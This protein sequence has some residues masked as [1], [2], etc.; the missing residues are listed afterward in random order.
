MRT[1]PVFAILIAA[2][3]M[4]GAAT[5]CEKKSSTGESGGT[6]TRAGEARRPASSVANLTRS[7]DSAPSCRLASPGPPSHPPATPVNPGR[8]PGDG[9]AQNVA[10]PRHR[11][12]GMLC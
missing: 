5:G 11:E 4:A 8:S 7:Q 10:A 9:E 3:L 2:A 6:K 12:M 1:R